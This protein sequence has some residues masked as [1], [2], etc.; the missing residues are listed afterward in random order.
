M[1]RIKIFGDLGPTMCV[2]KDWEDKKRVCVASEL[3]KEGESY[4]ENWKS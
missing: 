3:R 2:H 4:K 1:L